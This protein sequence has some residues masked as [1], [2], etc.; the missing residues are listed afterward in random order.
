MNMDCAP[1]RGVG[2]IFGPRREDVQEAVEK[3]SNQGGIK[4]IGH[5]ELIGEMRNIHNFSWKT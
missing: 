2:R 3:I 5:L 4:Q 1:R